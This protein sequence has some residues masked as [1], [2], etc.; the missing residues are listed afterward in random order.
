MEKKKIILIL[1]VTG[2]SMV[3]AACSAIGGSGTLPNTGGVNVDEA[4]VRSVMNQISANLGVQV[5][6]IEVVSIEQKDWPDACLGLPNAGEACAEIITPGYQ[7]TVK[8]NGQ[9]YVFRT[10]ESGSMV[11]QEG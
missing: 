9:E 11:R 4:T 6:D 1:L 8:V 5:D 3:I 7:V 2:L 10:D